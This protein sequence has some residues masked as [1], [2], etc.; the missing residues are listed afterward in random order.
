MTSGYT[1]L[2]EVGNAN[3]EKRQVRL[4]LAPG[5]VERVKTLFNLESLSEIDGAQE[6]IRSEIQTKPLLF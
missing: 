2:I 1:L 5:S 3:V 4:V 6:V